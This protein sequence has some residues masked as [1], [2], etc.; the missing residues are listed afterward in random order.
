MS[1]LE[2]KLKQQKEQRERAKKPR[3]TQEYTPVEMDT[4]LDD[5]E[6]VF[7]NDGEEPMKVKT[8]NK[9]LPLPPTK[10]TGGKSPKIPHPEDKSSPNVQPKPQKKSSTLGRGAQ[11]STGMALMQEFASKKGKLPKSSAIT[12][13]PPTQRSQHHTPPP[14]KTT[15]ASAIAQVNP[16]AEQSEPLY[17]NTAQPK[18]DTPYQNME[19]NGPPAGP[20]GGGAR[21]TSPP[22]TTKSSTSDLSGAGHS[23]SEYQNFNFNAKKQP[24]PAAK[25]KPR[26]HMNGSTSPRINS[27]PDNSPTS[28]KHNNSEGVYQNTTFNRRH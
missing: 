11:T 9:P 17:A 23:Q 24:P 19:F 7:E 10:K 3:K 28:P 25:K 20:A 1:L 8:K 18:A 21:K 5:D 14:N 26:A 27:S 15:S 12:D 22:M 6:G 13:S 2:K 16:E 4:G